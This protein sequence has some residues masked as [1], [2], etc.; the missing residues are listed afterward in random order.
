MFTY[1]HNLMN[2]LFYSPDTT[3]R[4]R[5]AQ[6]PIANA[7]AAQRQ[8]MTFRPP[9]HDSL[10]GGDCLFL[11][12]D[13]Y[14]RV[15]IKE[16]RMLFCGQNHLMILNMRSSMKRYL[17]NAIQDMYHAFGNRILLRSNPF[18]PPLPH[19]EIRVAQARNMT[20]YNSPAKRQQIALPANGNTFNAAAVLSIRG[21]HIPHD[22]PIAKP[23]LV[24]EELV[25]SPDPAPTAAL[26]IDTGISDSNSQ[27]A[28][29]HVLLAARS[30][31]DQVPRSPAAALPVEESAAIM[32]DLVSL[33][34]SVSA[35]HKI[36]IA[37]IPDLVSLPPSDSE[38][39]EV[40]IAE[41][42]DLVSLP[43]SDTEDFVLPTQPLLTSTPD[44]SQDVMMPLQPLLAATPDPSPRSAAPVPDLLTMNFSDSDDEP[45]IVSITPARPV[46]STSA[47]PAARPVALPAARNATS[48]SA[49]QNARKRKGIFS[50][51]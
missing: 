3:Q 26:R 40:N 23:M 7:P 14:V 16:T 32:P 41:I 48:T 31:S 8:R 20:V 15:N 1:S 33:P 22:T 19:L 4:R 42:P 28:P 45:I 37:E 2:A 30:D 34:P 5:R 27:Q 21:C 46:A 12:A 47:L 36:N 35:R 24:V 11:H 6:S 43:P 25:I 38:S 50:L 39:E 18:D 17:R 29:Q 13:E 51:F 44:S 10:N 9:L 49:A